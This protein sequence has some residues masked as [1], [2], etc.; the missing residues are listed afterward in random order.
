MF[1]TET[2]VG[3]FL[4]RKLKRGVMPPLA[5]PSGSAPEIIILPILYFEN[6]S[7]KVYGAPLWQ[8]LLT[9]PST[10]LT[11]HFMNLLQTF[12]LQN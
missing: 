9:F 4:V 10:K 7:W 2:G 11:F 5:L 8:I 3:P 12:S 1:E 6:G